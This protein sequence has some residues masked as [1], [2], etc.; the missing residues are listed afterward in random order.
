[1]KLFFTIFAAILAAAAV[2]WGAMSWAKSIEK[3]KELPRSAA[4]HMAR[5]AKILSEMTFK[6]KLPP[7]DIWEKSSLA[8]P[9]QFADTVSKPWPSEGP[10]KWSV[11]TDFFF[12]YGDAVK[13]AKAGGDPRSVAWAEEMKKRLAEAA[14]RIDGKIKP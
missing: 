6:G 11:R 5:S 4:L 2:V 13:A 12:Y 10:S 1:M 7:E 3:D 14:E 8:A 9:A